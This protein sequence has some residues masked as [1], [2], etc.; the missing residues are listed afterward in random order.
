[1]QDEQL[2]FGREST[3]LK[4]RGDLSMASRGK[5]HQDLYIDM[6]LHYEE[7]LEKMRQ[8]LNKERSKT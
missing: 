5:D 2:S 8:D 3:I 1:M 4:N 7:Q 6:K